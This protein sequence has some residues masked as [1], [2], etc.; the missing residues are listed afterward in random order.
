[1]HREPRKGEKGGEEKDLQNP[2]PF[3]LRPSQSVVAMHRPYP[4]WQSGMPLNSEIGAVAPSGTEGAKS[5]A[6]L[7]AERIGLGA[8]PSGIK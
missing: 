2:A 7:A 1:M 3:R 4:N 5:S 6:T 8:L